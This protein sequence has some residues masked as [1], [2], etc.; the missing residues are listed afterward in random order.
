MTKKSLQASI[1][2]RQSK[3][4][5]FS[6]E[7]GGGTGVVLTQIAKIARLDLPIKFFFYKKDRLSTFSGEAHFVNNYYS[8]S[9]YPSVKKA[10][11]LLRNFVNTLKV[12]DKE[13]P[14]L[15]LTFDY[16]SFALLSLIKPLFPAKLYSSH[17]INLVA[18]IL[19]KPNSIY[20]MALLRMTSLLSKI[21]NLH[22]FV[23]HGLAKS[24]IKAFH[25][26]I[27]KSR[28]I[29]NGVDLEKIK[30]L[31]SKKPQR[32]LPKTRYSIVSVGRLSKQKDYPTLLTA[33]SLLLYKLP[34]TNL[35]IV[36]DGPEKN[37]LLKLTKRLGIEKKVIFLGWVDN[38]FPYLS[39]AD[40]F[41]FS[42]NYEGFGIT[43][44][45]AMAAGVPVISTQTPY[46]P[47]EIIG[48]NK[49]GILVPMGDPKSLSY[50]MQKLLRS[51]DLRKKYKKMGLKRAKDFSTYTMQEK[52]KKLFRGVTNA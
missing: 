13:S 47:A 29:Y 15:V 24:M 20:R 52:Y 18:Y 32:L 51:K 19:D 7:T 31:G 35:F 33:F 42:S 39:Q 6:K 45:E 8:E 40:I 49:F 9:D 5:V 34:Q 48:K 25:I 1:A 37:K 50:A 4:V 41:V 11:I 38:F 2:K 28:V 17:H 36:S 21:P 26:P 30:S 12:I 22:I 43:I 46:G 10:I 44:I 14:D 27:A 3:I 16:Y 23:S